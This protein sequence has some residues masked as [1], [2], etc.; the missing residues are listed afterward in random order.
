MT[1]DRVLPW[2]QPETGEDVWALWEVVYRDVVILGPGNEHLGSFNLT[3]NDL[4][5]P[6]NYAALKDQLLEA[7][8][9]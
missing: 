4:S 3:T 2:L 5:D 7:A 8:G 6:E 1:A 9:H